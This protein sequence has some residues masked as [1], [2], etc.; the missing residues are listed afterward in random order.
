MH[1]LRGSHKHYW[2]YHNSKWICSSCGVSLPETNVSLSLV[3][4]DDPDLLSLI[5][6]YLSADVIGFVTQINMLC[7]N[8]QCSR[9]FISFKNN[10]LELCSRSVDCVKSYYDDTIWAYDLDRGC[11]SQ[12]PIYGK[13]HYIMNG[14]YGLNRV[15]HRLIW[16]DHGMYFTLDGSKYLIAFKDGV[17]LKFRNNDRFLMDQVD[18]ISTKKLK[19]RKRM[20]INSL[21]VSNVGRFE[22]VRYDYTKFWNLLAHFGTNLVSIDL[23]GQEI[24]DE[25]FIKIVFQLTVCRSLDF[26]SNLISNTGYLYL[27]NSKLWGGTLKYLDLTENRLNLTE[28]GS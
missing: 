20:N 24:T 2:F 26:A 22:R 5:L 28:L 3:C 21:V 16:C 15:N 9:L 6:C 17:T 13:K 12:Y 27:K 11:Y 4:F 8:R 18:S 10:H 19:K 7:L 14:M 25:Q 23:P 1:N